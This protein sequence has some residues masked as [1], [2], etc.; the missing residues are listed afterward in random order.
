M[1]GNNNGSE[2][3]TVII[4]LW[5]LSL[6]RETKRKRLHL[7]LAA[8]DTRTI[9]LSST[10]TH[11][12]YLS[13]VHTHAHTRTHTLYLSQVHT[14]ARTLTVSLKLSPAFSISPSFEG[15]AC[16]GLLS[17][18]MWTNKHAAST[19]PPSWAQPHSKTL[20]SRF[21]CLAFSLSLSLPLIPGNLPSSFSV[22]LQSSPLQVFF[23]QLQFSLEVRVIAGPH[24][25]C[26]VDMI[27][28]SC[29]VLLLLLPPP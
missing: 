17:R 8:V 11:T 2:T 6:R 9:F 4:I 10:R 19:P 3:R 14:H 23:Q 25:F 7:L 1:K 13:Q 24:H 15:F 27:A 18:T 16:Q 22:S 28:E 26:L 20:S 21:Y 12:L 29:R 5:F